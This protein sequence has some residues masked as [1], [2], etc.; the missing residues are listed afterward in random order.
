M[1]YGKMRVFIDLVETVTVKDNEGFSGMHEEV[2]ASLRAYMEQRHGNES[3]KNR[4]AFST[5]TAMF[6]FRRIP[7]IE[8]TTRH[9][10]VCAEGRYEIK[11]CEDVRNRGMYIEVLC[12]KVEASG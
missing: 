8:V 4:A 3:W 9:R 2:V 12:E 5:A 11:S 10:I 7:G 6:R 1:G